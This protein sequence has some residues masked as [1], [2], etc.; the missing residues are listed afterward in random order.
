MKSSKVSWITNKTLLQLKRKSS[1]YQIRSK[2]DWLNYKKA[3]NQVN[4][5]RIITPQK[6]PVKNIIQRKHGNQ[7]ITYWVNKKKTKRR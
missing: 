2:L 4:I 7:L 6:L 5:K 1:Y 3:R